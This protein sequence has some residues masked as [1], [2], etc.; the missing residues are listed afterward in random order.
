[1]KMKKQFL[2]FVALLLFNA[3]GYGQVQ[4]INLRPLED[5]Q[6]DSD[7][8]TT[9][10]RTAPEINSVLKIHP[11][12]N[13]QR[14]RSFLK[15]DF[16]SIP[17]NAVITSAQ[18]HLYNSG[19]PH[20][21]N[22]KLEIAR[23]LLG[24]PAIGAWSEGTIIW[25]N[26]PGYSPVNL[27]SLPVTTGSNDFLADVTTLTQDIV[28]L[29]ALNMA[30]NE[31]FILKLEN[32]LPIPSNEANTHIASNDFS[33]IMMRPELVISYYVPQQIVLNPDMI[34][35]L[36]SSMN[37]DKLADEQLVDS[38]GTAIVFDFGADLNPSLDVVIDLQ[39]NYQ[40]HELKFWRRNGDTIKISVS[41][42]DPN[43]WQ[44]VGEVK[45]ASW[46]NSLPY[47]NSLIIPPNNTT[48]F[49]KLHFENQQANLSEVFISGV[50]MGD[51]HFVQDAKHNIQAKS[52]DQLF[53]LN[54]FPWTKGELL[55]SGTSVR[56]YHDWEYNDTS[57][58]EYSF[59]TNKIENGNYFGF[60]TY[61]NP[62]DERYLAWKN[63]GIDINPCIQHS[64]KYIVGN[65]DPNSKPV[66][67]N[68]NP[69]YPSSYLSHAKFLYQFAARYGSTVFVP[70][71]LTSIKTPS[72]NPKITG[73][74]YVKY[75]ENWNEPDKWWVGWGFTTHVTKVNF[76]PFELAAMASADYDGHCNT[77][78]SDVGILNADPNMK[79]I[80]GSLAVI[81]LS[82]I[83][84][85]KLWSEVNRSSKTFP[86][87]VI[88]FHH[89]CNDANGQKGVSTTGISPEKD[90]L[91]ERLKEVVRYRNA[92]LPGI[93]IWLTEFGYDT[94]PN[95]IIRSPALGTT[96]NYETQARWMLRSYLEIAAS[97]IDR[98]HWYLT[99]DQVSD[100][101]HSPGKFNTCGL[102]KDV[103]NNETK[104]TAW[105]YMSF[106]KS[107]L[108][109]Y[110]FAQEV[111]STLS[112]R[113]YKFSKAGEPDYY[114]IWSPTN[115][116]ATITYKLSVDDSRR[117]KVYTPSATNAVG[118][119][120]T[121][122]SSSNFATI[123]ASELPVLVRI[124]PKDV[125]PPVAN[126]K[127][128]KDI[129]L[130]NNGEA[131]LTPQD[132]ENGST[133]NIG[134]VSYEISRSLFNCNDVIEP[135]S[136][137]FVSD[138]A[139]KQSTVLLPNNNF[140][141]TWDHNYVL[142]DEGTYNLNAPIEQPYSWG[143][144]NLVP[145]TEPIS[146]GG[147]ITFFK[148]TF[149]V[150]NA[151][152]SSIKLA[153]SMDDNVDVYLNGVKL[154]R[155]ETVD[156]MNGIGAPHEIT[157]FSSGGYVNGSNGFIP[158]ETVLT[159]N[160]S[161]ILVSG[162]NT[163]HVVLRNLDP[164]T[165]D[166][167]GFSFKMT[168]DY[169]GLIPVT[170]TVK[171]DD[172]NAT[173]ATTFIR[174]HDDLLPVARVKNHTLLLSGGN[175]TLTTA[176]VEN[177]SSDNCNAIV[178]T[179]LSKTSF[180]CADYSPQEALTIA[181]DVT[182]QLSPE[183]KEFEWNPW[184]D[185]EFPYTWIPTNFSLNVNTN[186][187]GHIDPV[188]GAMP[189]QAENDIRFYR[190]TFYCNG[191]SDFSALIKAT[192]DDQLRLFIN[193]H[194][195][196]KTGLVSGNNT[197]TP[198]IGIEFLANG[199]FL[200]NGVPLAY[201]TNLS[202]SEFLKHGENEII[203]VV[204]N[205]IN[206][207]QGA[208]SFNMLA[209]S[210]IG[211]PVTYTVQ[212]AKGYIGTETAYITVKDPS[213]C[214]LYKMGRSNGVNEGTVSTNLT[215]TLEVYPNPV[216]N[217]L[218]IKQNTDKVLPS[219]I[220]ISDLTGKVVKEINGFTQQGMMERFIDVSEFAAGLLLVEVQT[221]DQISVHK[222][223]KY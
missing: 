171:D 28:D 76:K 164:A 130:N 91:K 172:E 125:V 194:L 104:K 89:Y 79:M 182:W 6:V 165:P 19:M 219:R 151:N 185:G 33:N 40:L 92:Y 32:E 184:H 120:S 51:N 197:I 122:N 16:S 63:L 196:L 86:A 119:I 162:E 198:G 87:D 83:K 93:E 213:N 116:N 200:V 132:I 101:P 98:A 21:G 23:V 135:I 141:G 216:G 177:G 189:I 62:M 11:T 81:D 123:I 31:G 25:N 134:I 72:D 183:F 47:W 150:S 208:F 107:K 149:N 53:G 163:I 84:A 106:F 74:N 44:V 50:R 211:T 97:G 190:K 102:A 167:G 17:T 126:A 42:G 169:D 124:V 128:I 199:G 111:V 145:G 222:I 68:D 41:V 159:S 142:P 14:I 46:I 138:P 144:I 192:V 2:L 217:K 137:E 66:L 157:Y 127:T 133:D 204:Q 38:P 71:K 30:N 187:N 75:M 99:N 105:Y 160:I 1:M 64:P 118:T 9:N 88:S 178:T 218:T 113:V 61:K 69:L 114:A 176:N 85:I 117:V 174:V 77:L 36:F 12:G 67:A 207:D 146:A 210:L 136:L 156:V 112:L 18:L 205:S 24:P 4:S 54:G 13:F 129:Y 82:Y 191:T 221:G 186:P 22:N 7:S 96:S 55:T 109:G 5:A 209:K 48:R 20:T 154:V 140:N 202:A 166:R 60:H 70:S 215:N 15:F 115:S 43:N 52:Y 220:K 153:M 179:S 35:P 173:S 95:S 8:P 212:D 193:G 131:I 78:G 56:E 180:S 103:Y 65:N 181:S 29:M 45:L 27:V 170:L 73:L 139:W 58:L 214:G 143:G 175:A 188:A 39:G 206:A 90:H 100:T 148:R 155:V 59:K 158:F 26:Q 168:I 223:L 121:I 49:V 152:F 195:I 94:D 203:V 147:D 110:H 108:A 161:G 57:G 3:Y 10:Y 80:L 37:C 34:C 201:I